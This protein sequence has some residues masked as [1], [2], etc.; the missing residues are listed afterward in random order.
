MR[1]AIA[2]LIESPI[3]DMLIRGDLKPGM[4]ALVG[5]ENG[6]ISVD[7]VYRTDPSAVPP[8]VRER[9]QLRA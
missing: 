6:E 5:E 3:A 8:P 1:R 4:A 2:R 9:A 7:A